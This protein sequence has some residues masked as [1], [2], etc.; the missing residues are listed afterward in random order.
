MKKIIEP[1][2]IN[3]FQQFD[4]DVDN[5][6]I[7]LF[8]REEYIDSE[9][10]EEPGVEYS[11]ANRLIKNVTL[12]HTNSKDKNKYKPIIIHMKTN[13]GDFN[14]GMAI[15]DTLKNIPNPIIIVNYTHARSMSSI[16]FQ[17]ASKRVMMPHSFLMIHRGT[18]GIS[19]TA[20][21]V[22][23]NYEFDKRDDLIMLDIYASRMKEKGI[24][25]GRSKTKI[26]EWLKD[27]MMKKTDVFM[28]AEQA[29][30]YGL[31]DEVFTSWRRIR[32]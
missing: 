4:V 30:K 11:M 22:D 7:Y 10:D 14:E 3:N 9:T 12:C 21:E 25:K 17:A 2:K 18:Y 16:I 29:I 28:T 15:Y 6:E 1:N 26:K 5:L 20:Q 31:A 32:K 8:G 23:S 24:F 13:G 19:G 27:Q